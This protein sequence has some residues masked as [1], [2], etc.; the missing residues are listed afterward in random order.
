MMGFPIKIGAM[1]KTT[2]DIFSCHIS[3]F[4]P[5]FQAVVAL[6]RKKHLNFHHPFARG[7][8]E[9]LLTDIYPF[10]LKYVLPYMMR[11]I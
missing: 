10:I 9:A 3:H 11:K 7:E 5:R 1:S 2:Y 8:T 4:D 6:L